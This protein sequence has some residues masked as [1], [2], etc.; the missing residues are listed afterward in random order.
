MG[1]TVRVVT[2]E[3]LQRTQHGFSEREKKKEKEKERRSIPLT[4]PIQKGSLPESA[5]PRCGVLRCAV[6]R[7]GTV[8]RAILSRVAWLVVSFL[9]SFVGKSAASLVFKRRQRE[10]V[11]RTVSGAAR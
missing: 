2:A 5:M 3:C 4:L 1:C 8:C 7:C 11:G 6:P 9:Y 10:R